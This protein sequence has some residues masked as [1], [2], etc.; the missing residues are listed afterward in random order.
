M[1]GLLIRRLEVSTGPDRELDGDL[2]W[3]LD[4]AAAERV[5]NTG[6]LGLPRKYPAS[7][8]IPAGLGR[9]GVYAMA[10]RLSSSL[11]AALALVERALPGWRKSVVVLTPDPCEAYVWDANT[12][13]IGHDHR[14]LAPT[15]A[16]ALCLALCRAL[17]AQE[18]RV[19]GQADGGGDV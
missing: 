8:P 5:Y 17:Q 10:P 11:D 14:S 2:W 19:A 3:T 12:G 16:L 18:T 4:H 6:A 15:P 7:L 9:A 1:D 13:T